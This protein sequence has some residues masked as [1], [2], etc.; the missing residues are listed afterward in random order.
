MTYTSRNF[1][2]GSHTNLS[3]TDILDLRVMDSALLASAST[4]GV[5]AFGA[6][7]DGE[8]DDTNAIQA[9]IDAVPAEGGDVYFPAGNYVVNGT[10]TIIDRE[11]LRLVGQGPSF[12]PYGFLDNK[13]TTWLRTSGSGIMLDWYASAL[14][15]SA[16]SNGIENIAFDGANLASTCVRLRSQYGGVW[17]GIKIRDATSVGLDLGTVDLSGVQ[18]LQAN[19]FEQIAV[20]CT[21]TT[22]KGIRLSSAVAGEG[23][24][25]LNHFTFLIVYTIDGTGI[26]VGDSDGNVFTSTFV[27]DGGSAVSIDLLG[28]NAVSSGYARY[29]SFYFTQT[30]GSIT[31]RGTGT[32]TQPAGPNFFLLSRGNGSP[33]PTIEAG[34]TLYYITDTGVIANSG[35]GQSSSTGETTGFTA[36]GGTT[37]TH[38]STFTGNSGT[39]AYTIG[40]I[41]K[42]LKANGILA[43]S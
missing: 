43:S 6:V 23:N 35:S 40:D 29:N 33:L 5:T 41:V 17:R 16:R 13:G 30:A 11:N 8:T 21:A 7:G 15:D 4:V 25:S 34:S 3:I 18:D 9:A 1:H 39:K 27:S 14:T 38:S 22:A 12:Y 20:T 42:H 28:T 31:S 26:E 2:Q 36:G 19:I 37:V 10:V 24:V 32:Y